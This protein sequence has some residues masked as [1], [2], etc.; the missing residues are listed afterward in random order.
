[1]KVVNKTDFDKD[2]NIPKKSII[3]DSDFTKRESFFVEKMQDGEK[4]LEAKQQNLI[5][6]INVNLSSIPFEIHNK[7]VAT[8]IINIVLKDIIARYTILNGLNVNS[9]IGFLHTD[10]MLIKN[11]EDSTTDSFENFNTDQ[12]TQVKI[13]K[14]LIEKNQVALEKNIRSQIVDIMNLGVM[15]NYSKHYYSTLKTNISA[16]MLNKFESLYKTGRI[17]HEIRPVTWCTKCEKSVLQSEIKY[18]KSKVSN[19]YI[20]FKI[21]NDNG[22]LK[23]ITS[24]EN[25][26]I[27]SS[28]IRPWTMVYEYEMSAAK[29]T[30]YC[31]VEVEDINKKN[32]RYII[33]KE[34]VDKTMLNAF[35]L[36]YTIKTTF[37]ADLLSEL[38]VFNPL[39]ESTSTKI[40]VID[41]KLVLVDKNNMTGINI[42]SNADCYLDYIILKN[43]NKSNF[44]CIIDKK[45]NI[46]NL[47]PEYKGKNYKEVNKLVISKL[48]KNSRLFLA[49]NAVI[50][51][52]RCKH[53][54]E[55]IVYRDLNKWF[56][57]RSDSETES[58]KKCFEELVPKIDDAVTNNTKLLQNSLNKILKMNELA[59]SD[60][61]QC[62]VPIPAFSCASCGEIII[63]DKTINI[64][65]NIILKDGIDK[66][67]KMTPDEILNKS[68]RCPKCDCD[69]FFKDES[70]INEDFKMLTLPIFNIEKDPRF[71]NYKARQNINLCIEPRKRFL[72]KL[73]V[74]SFD[75]NASKK[76]GSITQV[77]L[78]P[79]AQEEKR[80]VNDPLLKL[81]SDF[82]SNIINT[83]IGIV[84]IVKKY[85]IDVLRLW[86]IYRS[87]KSSMKLSEGDIVTIRNIYVKFRKTVKY[88]LSNLYDFD[89]NKDFIP[90]EK[91][92]SL[93]KFLYNKM[94]KIDNKLFG[95]YNLL[96]FIGIYKTL[97]VFCVNSLQESYFE[98]IRYRLYITKSNG[99]LRRSTQ[100]TLYELL[101]L[102][103]DYLYPIL[104][105]LFEECWPYIHHK[106][107]EIEKNN[108]LFRNETV[109]QP[110]TISEKE[111][112]WE[113][114]FSMKRKITP[115]INKACNEH[116]I[117]NSLG[118]R[119]DIT[120]NTEGVD[121][122]KSH[123]EDIVRTLN[124]S[125]VF[126]KPGEKFDVI[127]KQAAGV[128][129]ARCKNYSV[130]IGL[131]FK[132]RYL[133]PICAEIEENMNKFN[134]T[135]KEHLKFPKDP[136]TIKEDLKNIVPAPKFETIIDTN[137]DDS[138]NF[139]EEY[140][141]KNVPVKENEDSL[142]STDT[143]KQK[144]NISGNE[145]NIS[146]NENAESKK[147][148]SI[149]DI[150]QYN[151]EQKLK[152]VELAYD[153]S[154]NTSTSKNNHDFG[155]NNELS[156]DD[157]RLG[158]DFDDYD[159]NKLKQ[160]KDK[161]NDKTS[162]NKTIEEDLKTEEI[163][164]TNKKSK[165]EEFTK[166]NNT[167]DDTV[168]LKTILETNSKDSNNSNV[169]D[170]YSNI[171]TNDVQKNDYNFANN[172]NVDK[173]SNKKDDT[174]SH[175]ADKKSKK[176]GLFSLIFSKKENNTDS[177]KLSDASNDISEEQ[178]KK[179]QEDK[180]KIDI[181]MSANINTTQKENK[182]SSEKK[183]N[184]ISNKDYNDS[185][186][187]KADTKETISNS[188]KSNENV[189][190][191]SKI[192]TKV[193]KEELQEKN[194]NTRTSTVSSQQSQKN[195]K[196]NESDSFDS[197]NDSF[198]D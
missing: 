57:I 117:K 160:E 173:F 45:G 44:K 161:T 40:H 19:T 30:K 103:L 2:I 106:T 52:P 102:L 198:R 5:N 75:D 9:S 25:T 39:N 26:Y 89:P 169:S 84:D 164:D 145:E 177:D 122:I 150:E 62:N 1:M 139:D 68:I 116:I 181:A 82:S 120:C 47:I 85:G 64:C 176:V 101:E 20:L 83:N 141:I 72:N 136:N 133:C 15:I 79:Q 3:M 142:N 27:V 193:K 59:I 143:I 195:D 76:I 34:F 124:V 43:L 81:N 186:S 132:Y 94:Q 65:K 70:S 126:A 49:T 31:V 50:I 125:E 78:H 148:S 135:P 119:L 156:F 192:S 162:T 105:L 179:L 158:G 159:I 172:N 96:N 194:E 165:P 88:V 138:R 4:Y 91:R 184:E 56:L 166:V 146:S 37:D 129:C 178:L 58:L 167:V 127:V 131:N 197:F 185:K 98:A 38:E 28:T 111:R 17:T 175:Y 190:D 11:D 77:M 87:N 196:S 109:L 7:L 73:K 55:E 144:N 149:A 110:I 112:D 42:V 48:K 153:Y 80:K 61:R 93:D 115:Y 23:D 46:N 189:D 92:D 63:N 90:I 130:D 16:K 41:Q 168:A 69:F 60:E 152:E 18:R 187:S 171:T 10:E 174:N 86:A 21:K 107:L 134:Y 67:N 188:I 113:K 32:T 137:F 13:S 157:D 123:Y 170:N 66:Y 71:P 6:Q 108:L 191:K 128:A 147:T 99:F 154:K 163:K 54:N 8:N 140:E 95:Y 33:A 53:C 180:A 36:K 151:Y 100:S 14:G 118:A 22:K 121:F 104:P 97:F 24:L 183:S 114:I 155:L 51:I 74:S 35:F 182:D 29:D 12:S